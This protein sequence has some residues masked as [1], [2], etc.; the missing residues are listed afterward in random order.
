MTRDVR[1][2]LTALAAVSGLVAAFVLVIALEKT[3]GAP[4]WLTPTL[5]GANAV[6]LVLVLV[7][8]AWRRRTRRDE[9]R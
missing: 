1:E 8:A 6:I 2:S 9:V 5:E 4:Q 3:F 7:R